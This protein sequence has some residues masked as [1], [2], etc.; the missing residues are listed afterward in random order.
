VARTAKDTVYLE[1]W[2][3]GRAR[4][5]VPKPR[6]ANQVRSVAGRVERAK[7]VRRVN[8][9]GA[10]GGLLVTFD[11]DD[12]IDMIVDELKA[13]GLDIVSLGAP[14]AAPVRTQS[15]GAAVLRSVMSRANAKLHETTRG[16]LDLRLAIPAFYALLAVRGFARQRGRL[17]EASWYQLAYWAFDSFFKLHEEQTV[18]PASRSNGR[19]VD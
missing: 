9:N 10:T 16:H 2:M 12:P 5:R 17:R 15:T 6:T 8:A 4:L 7:R 18:H 3:P 11:A 14:S 19:I 13:L 1:H